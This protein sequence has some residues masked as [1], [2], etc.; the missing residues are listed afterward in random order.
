MAASCS[1]IRLSFSVITITNSASHP[2]TKVWVSNRLF[3]DWNVKQD[4][5]WF[6]NSNNNVKFG[7]QGIYHKFLPGKVES[8]GGSFNSITTDD[9][10][11]LE[12]GVYI[13]NDQKFGKLIQ[14]QYGI[15]YSI[16]NY[17]GEGTAYTFNSDGDVLTEQDYGSWES[18]QTYHGIEPRVA[19]SVQMN[20]ESAIKTSY[21]RNYQ[22]LHLLSNSVSSSPT[23]VWVP[24]SNN[25]KPQIVD[26]VSLGYFRTFKKGKYSASI[27]TYYKW[28]DN[29]IDYKNGADLILNNTIESELVYGKG[30][31]FGVELMVEKKKGR[32][33]GW[34]SYTLSRT[35]RQ[36]D[37]IN[38]GEEF[39]ARQDRIHDVSVVGMFEV[40][41]KITLSAN[42]I[43]YTGDAVTFPSGRY[44]VDGQIVPL[45]TDRNAARM[46]D[47]HRLDLGF[48]WKFA[49]AKKFEHSLNI[50][51]Y[52]VYARENAYSISFRQNADDPTKTEAV[53]LSLFRIIPSITYN[54]KF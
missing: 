2:V 43:Y 22:Y 47:Y 36:F 6:A 26:Q 52:N 1:P 29:Q 27:D 41:D 34:V 42:F 12:G 24:A 10:Y 44:I 7:V 38:G 9:K 8:S 16:F 15:R 37:E 46:P 33:T 45:Y 31:S 35:L 21:N 19:V 32:F 13:Q 28:L 20:E 5:S 23:D 53:Q 50:S 49:K 14:A 17:M 18:I 48:L 54:I 4:Y 40:N 30:R 25:V 3:R 51:V 11:A 39:S